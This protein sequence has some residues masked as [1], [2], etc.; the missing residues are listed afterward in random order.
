MESPELKKLQEQL[1]KVRDQKK[2]TIQDFTHKS[3][4]AVNLSEQAT[5]THMSLLD[6]D[7]EIKL[8]PSVKLRKKKPAEP[9][10]ETSD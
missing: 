4:D 1:K 7:S 10:Q 5:L 8:R 3:I 9:S 2:D 6:S